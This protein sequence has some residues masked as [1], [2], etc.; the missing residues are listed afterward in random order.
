MNNYSNRLRE[1]KDHYKRCDTIHE[2]INTR[3]IKVTETTVKEIEYTLLL[4]FLSI[5]FP[6]FN[7]LNEFHESINSFTTPHL[8]VGSRTTRFGYDPIL[9]P[10]RQ[11]TSFSKSPIHDKSMMI[12]QNFTYQ[13]YRSII[14]ILRSKGWIN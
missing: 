5:P 2:T 14:Y 3:V 1:S 13:K 9:S 8:D 6:P 11:Y 7:S 12:F 4:P 10:R